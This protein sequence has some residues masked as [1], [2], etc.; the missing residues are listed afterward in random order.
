MKPLEENYIHTP[1]NFE[2]TKEDVLLKMGA[3]FG[4]SN[5]ELMANIFDLEPSTNRG[6]VRSL[7]L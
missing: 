3:K 4:K 5:S 2:D 1:A 6:A 7:F